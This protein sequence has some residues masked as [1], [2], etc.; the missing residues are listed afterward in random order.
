MTNEKVTRASEKLL[1]KLQEAHSALE[2][3]LGAPYELLDLLV[4]AVSKGEEPTETWELLH[5][6]AER[7]GKIQELA[8]AYESVAADK[9]VRLLCA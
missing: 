7:D 9:R 4:T 6:A 2:R 1:G 3:A 8:F 5:Q